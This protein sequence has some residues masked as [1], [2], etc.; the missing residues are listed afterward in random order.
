MRRARCSIMWL[1]FFAFLLLWLPSLGESY[2]LSPSY[3]LKR[4]VWAYSP[5]RS[6]TVDQRVEAYGEDTAYPFDSIDEKVVM[7]PIVPVKIWVQG[8]AVT[9]ESD[10]DPQLDINPY[11]IR[12]QHWYGFYKDV[13]LNHQVNLVMSLLGRLGVSP[14]ETR[15]RLLYPDIAYQVGNELTEENI[16]GLWVDKERF[17]PL[18]LAGTLIGER[19][20]K[21]FQELIDIRY[22]DYRLLNERFWYPFDIQIFVN[23]KLS[24]RIRASSVSL[25]TY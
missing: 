2:L 21:P 20:G 5:L 7:E 17:I 25:T 14:V 19:D 13:F 22:G 6:I 23:G 15:L 9:G 18:R 8:K 16:R 12:V 10:I 24:L 11:L 3:I 4:L 1:V